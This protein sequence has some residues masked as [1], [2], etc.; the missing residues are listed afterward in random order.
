ML[1]GAQVR[2]RHDGFDFTP[3]VIRTP[4]LGR[5]RVPLRHHDTVC[6]TADRTLTD[7]IEVRL[8]GL[9]VATVT[10]RLGRR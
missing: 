2:L 3:Y 5:L 7:T 10:M 1:G 8:L 6:V 9:R 4:V